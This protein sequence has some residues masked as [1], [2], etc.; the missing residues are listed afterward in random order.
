MS[1]SVKKRLIE[2]LKTTYKISDADIAKAEK[3]RKDEGMRFFDALR[4]LE[5]VGEKE[6]TTV[7]GKQCGVP[8]LD[9]SKL[10]IKKELNKMI[11]EKVARRYTV[12]PVSS[13]GEQIT[14]AMADPLNLF[15]VDD[16]KSLTNFQVDVVI[17]TEKDILQALDDL[18]RT[19][20]DVEEIIGKHAMAAADD[21]SLV[22]DS[23][24]IGG[25][26][27][28]VSSKPIVRIVDLILME[29]Y[30]KGAS[31][32]HIEPTE[33]QVRVRYRVDGY[34]REALM[35]P[36][37]NQ[38]AVTARIKILAN[39]DITENRVPQDGRFKVRFGQRELDYRV[40]VLPIYWG[41]KIVMRALDKTNLRL[42]LEAIGI[43]PK[44]LGDFA[45]GIKRPFGMMI[46]T[47]PTGSGKSTTLYSILS[48]MNSVQRNIITVE[49]P[50]EYQL[51]GITQMQTRPEIGFTF[52]QG[53]R[54]ILR[55]SPD[56]V[57][58]G[59][60]RDGETADIAVKAALTGQ[61]VLSTLHTN[62][63]AS[64]F[65]R[66]VDMGVEPFLISSS[67]TLVAAQRLCRKICT[68]CKDK[69][70]IPP[71]AFER[72]GVTAKSVFGNEE[73]IAY[74]GRGCERCDKSGYKGRVAIAE[75]ILMNE[76]LRRMVEKKCSAAEIKQLALE[77]GMVTLRAD[78]LTKMKAGTT[79]FD[80]VLRVT[81][82]DES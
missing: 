44:A 10:K 8:F 56:I 54:A 36:K 34:L 53:L 48:A 40:S 63:A 23:H 80:E 67:I 81:A 13:I 43:G 62:D 29:A 65:T 51:A 16:I 76:A 37:K 75:T 11:P 19:D 30:K 71:E 68:Y 17:G 61:V 69:T 74:I 64:A 58:L 39:L 72:L 57:M 12:V 46:I 21:G 15:A 79:S 60:I 31:D 38:N 41:S 6:L 25:A 18:Y 5:L 2:A 49:D 42:D 7:L 9:I 82:E 1:K 47:G 73:P 59:E 3:L 78:A 24:M 55:Q 70:K 33:T 20:V 66:L 14:L 32:I 35:L 26:D 22:Q 45:Q 4:K 28:D 52:A 27:A 77:Q 50:I